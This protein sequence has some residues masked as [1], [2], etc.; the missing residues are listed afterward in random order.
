MSRTLWIHVV[1]MAVALGAPGAGAAA[2]SAEYGFDPMVAC[3]FMLEEGLR[4]RGGYRPVGSV[5]ECRSQRRNVMG[6]GPVNNTIRFSA[7]GSEQRVTQLELELRV[8]AQG[9]V[10][11]THRVLL[12]H[13]DSLFQRALGLGISSEIETAILAGTAGQWHLD[14]RSVSLERIPPGARRYGLRLRIE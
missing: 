5:Y 8:N 11:R 1:C 10:Q 2:A 6:G 3:D 12:N 7:R 4:T 14:G 9:A 13:A